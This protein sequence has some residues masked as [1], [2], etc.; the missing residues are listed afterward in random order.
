MNSSE[1]TISTWPAITSSAAQPF[2]RMSP[3]ATKAS[4]ANIPSLATELATNGNSVP[5][6][7]A[8]WSR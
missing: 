3:A 1:P 7:R 6:C 8:P 5:W 2:L 4:T